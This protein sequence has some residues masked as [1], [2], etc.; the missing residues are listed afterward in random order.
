MIFQVPDIPLDGFCFSFSPSFVVH[1]LRDQIPFRTIGQN[2]GPVVRN[3]DFDVEYW[4]WHDMAW[5]VGE[6]AKSKG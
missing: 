3:I 5:T 4:H 2:T 6:R 1:Y